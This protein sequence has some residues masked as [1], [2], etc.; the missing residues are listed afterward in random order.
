MNQ[1]ISLSSILKI[2]KTTL[3]ENDFDWIFK[4]SNQLNAEFSKNVFYFSFSSCSR[5]IEKNDIYT[6]HFEQFNT[7]ELARL[8]LLLTIPT[9]SFEAFKAIFYP[10]FDT[11]DVAEQEA[12]YLSFDFL[13]YKIELA[14]K[15]ALG[16]STNIGSVFEKLALKNAYPSKYLSENAFNQLVIKTL[17]TERNILDIIGLKNRLNPELSRMAKELAK[18]RLA[19]GR[20]LRKEVEILV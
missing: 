16:I 17:F 5:V 1:E 20:V 12:L 6:L 9:H 2:L 14:S 15:F 10:V 13:P 11:A 8:A 18:E 3:S 4:K 7:I 19:A